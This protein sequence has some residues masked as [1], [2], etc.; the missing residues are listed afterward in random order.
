MT[1]YPWHHTPRS[2]RC[3]NGDDSNPFPAPGVF[4]PVPYWQLQVHRQ[5][6]WCRGFAGDW[7]C[8]F[9]RAG[10]GHPS[11]WTLRGRRKC[12]RSY[13]RCSDWGWTCHVVVGY[14]LQLKITKHATNLTCWNLYIDIYLRHF[15]VCMLTCPPPGTLEV[16]RG[17]ELWT[18]IWTTSWQVSTTWE[19]SH[20]TR[21]SSVA[22]LSLGLPSTPQEL[23]GSSVSQ[24]NVMTKLYGTQNIQKFHNNLPFTHC[25]AIMFLATMSTNPTLLDLSTLFEYYHLS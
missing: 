3:Y 5:L 13:L 14:Y 24:P 4:D 25:S 19:L 17:A 11:G 22:L 15:T 2:K 16:A 8:Q 21:V 9:V 20:L 10:L 7:G 23:S 12:C 6:P 18:P 1:I